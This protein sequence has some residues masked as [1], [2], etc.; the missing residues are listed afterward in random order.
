MEREAELRKIYDEA[1]VLSEGQGKAIEQE[2]WTL[3]QTLLDA[4]ERC[5]QRAEQLLTQPVTPANK[6]ELAERLRQ[7]HQIDERN[8]Q[9]LDRKQQ[10]LQA[11]MENLGRS[12][13]A[14]HGYLDSFGGLMDPSF[15]D[16]DQ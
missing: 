4:R 1:L 14:L 10:A 16:Q 15:I 6:A 2:N 9:L 11:E 13:T 12:K 8:Q 3:L 5:I 7:L